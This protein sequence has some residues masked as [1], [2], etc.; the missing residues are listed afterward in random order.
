MS[1][2]QFLKTWF[3]RAFHNSWGAVEIVHK[4]CILFTALPLLLSLFVVFGV[5]ASSH[6]EEPKV[7]ILAPLV[8]AILVFLVSLV[9]H[10]YRLY[11][12]EYDRR[13]AREEQLASDRWR[14]VRDR[15]TGLPEG[16]RE[17]L[18]QLVIE[19]RIGAADAQTRFPGVDF[20]VLSARVG[21]LEHDLPPVNAWGVR[22]DSLELLRD[23]LIPEPDPQPA[24]PASI[25]SLLVRL[26]RW[27]S[28]FRRVV[29]AAWNAACAAMREERTRRYRR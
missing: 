13:A 5:R 4:A 29:E 11:R 9:L 6:E 28:G 3:T 24:A 18:R 16:Y 7:L 19:G 27:S 17:A 14:A 26:C 2:W 10:A 22:P 12:E 8:A 15:I 20:T 25:P 23:L 1:F 21:L